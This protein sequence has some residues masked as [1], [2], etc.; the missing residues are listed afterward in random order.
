MELRWT[1]LFQVYRVGGALK[2]GASVC[3][4]VNLALVVERAVLTWPLFDHLHKALL[5]E[6][7]LVP[8]A[9]FVL[10]RVV[11][12]KCSCHLAIWRVVASLERA[13]SRVGNRVLLMVGVQ[14]CLLVYEV[15]PLRLGCSHGGC[16][17]CVR[18]VVFS[19]I[20]MIFLPFSVLRGQVCFP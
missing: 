5:L 12:W 15:E 16:S 10:S 4:L 14:L 2:T 1:E 9:I 11:R 13:F 18:V 17:S 6:D 19:F 7:R 8:T 20:L 3:S